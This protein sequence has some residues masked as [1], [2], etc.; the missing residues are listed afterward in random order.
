M[1]TRVMLLIS[2]TSM[3]MAA[4][5]QGPST[6]VMPAAQI[7]QR[8]ELMHNKKVVVSTTELAPGKSVPMH[9]H[10][11]DYFTVVLTDGQLRE[12]VADQGAMTSGGKKMGRVFGAMH[13]PGASGDKLQAGEVVYN[14]AGY[15]HADENK[16]K[17]TMR[18]VTV[19][20]LEPAGKQQDASRKSNKYCNENDKN[21][22]VEEKY[23]FCTDRFCVEDVTMAPRAQST[24]HSHATD[25]MLIALTDY[26]LTDN[27]TGKGT[28]VRTKK[29]GEVEYIKSG[30]NHQL[31]NTGK[32]PARFIVVLFN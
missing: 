27:I 12:T 4:G 29:A 31:N 23:L 11:H 17:T 14:R 1:K 24:K 3:L 18:A 28:I 21:A 2:T 26:Q 8:H 15:T 10:E 30:I 5:A 9:R 19:D 13:V 25:H 32:L 16:G 20:F 7:P 6:P 22:C